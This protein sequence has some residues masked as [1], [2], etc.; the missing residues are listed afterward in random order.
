[1]V[2]VDLVIDVYASQRHYLDHLAPIWRGLPDELRGDVLFERGSLSDHPLVVEANGRKRK[3]RQ[4]LGAKRV[5]TAGIGDATNARRWGAGVA[6]VE[7]GAGQ[8]YLTPGEKAHPSYPGGEKRGSIGLFLCTNEAVAQANERLYGP[9]S[10]VIGSPRLSDLREARAAQRLTEPGERPVLALVWHWDCR[11]APE[12]FWAFPEFVPCLP[13]L[14]A[15]WPGK[16][17]GHAH[18]RVWDRAEIAYRGVGIEP[19]RDFVDVVRRADVVSFDSTSAGFEAAALG[20]PVV[21]VDSARWRRDVEHGLRFWRWAD[22]GPRMRPF[23][24]YPRKTAETWATLGEQVVVND[25][26]QEDRAAMTRVVYPHEGTEV[27]R[28]VEALRVWV[29]SPS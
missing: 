6:L 1:M 12:S 14:V 9:R 27:E 22:I 15:S 17:I 20:I 4:V 19:V 18:P 28:A 8:T 11:V 24:G 3:G 29:G 13:D 21:L 25:V 2:G 7:H 16:V 5:L 26:W 23:S 10:A